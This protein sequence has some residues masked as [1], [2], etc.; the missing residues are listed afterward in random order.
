VE[1]IDKS[2]IPLAMVGLLQALPGTQLYRRLVKEGRLLA[3]GDGN[4]TDVRLNFLPK[5]DPTRLVEGYRSILKRIYEHE[6][7]Y[8]RVRKFLSRYTPSH[9][10]I[11]SWSDY[12]A[13]VKSIVKQGVFGEARGAY[14]KFLFDAATHYRHAFGTAMTL[15]IMGYHLQT[16]TRQVLDAEVGVVPV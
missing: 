3:D 2:A 14:W 6:A 13:V 8:D 9:H 5:M 1:F 7:Y 11:R 15:A 4:N 16:I 10:Y 12:R